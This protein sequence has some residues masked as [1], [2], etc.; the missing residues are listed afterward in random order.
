MNQPMRK[1]APLFIV[2]T[3]AIATIVGGSVLYRVK[4]PAGTPLRIQESADTASGTTHVLGPANAPATLEEYGDFQCPPCGTLSA[5]LNQIVQDYRPRV[6][7]IFHEF[8]LASHSH[9]REAAL[10][11]EAAALQGKF[12]EMHDVL[13]R[14][15]P[16]WSKATDIRPL[17]DSYAGI[18]GLD[19]TRFKGDMQSPKI[20]E[21]VEADQ[22]HGNTI[23]V[24]NTPTIFLNN[25]AVEPEKLNAQALRA[26]LD[27]ILKPHPSP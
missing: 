20:K 21:R 11:A 1:V 4:K 19:V 22:Q 6:R 17:F 3:V 26:G 9:A 13:Y 5:P 12:W 7:L 10:A 2:L 14:E 18:L 15:Q 27:A 24:K 25:T 8:P 16:V 23:G